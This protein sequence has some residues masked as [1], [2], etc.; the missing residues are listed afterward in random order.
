MRS[1]STDTLDG[2]TPEQRLRA[3]GI[4]LPPAAPA[5]G[6]Y[7]PTAIAGS[8]L[9]TSGQLPWIAGDLKF[10]G[11]IGADLTP[12]QG[13]SDIPAQRPQCDRADQSGARQSRSR[14]AGGAP[15]GHDGL[16]T[17]LHRAAFS[18]QRRL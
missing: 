15:R 17:G 13:L 5:V 7:A 11:K 1:A 10:K 3:L 2:L 12:E 6:D 4:E 16:R 14:Q 18:A 9:M 8:L